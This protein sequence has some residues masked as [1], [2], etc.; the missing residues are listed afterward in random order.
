MPTTETSLQHCCS[1]FNGDIISFSPDYTQMLNRKYYGL[2][3]RRGIYFEL[4]YS[5]AIVNSTDRKKIISRG[6]YYHAIGKS[7]NVLLNSGAENS[8]ELRSPYDVANLGLIFGLSEE[9]GKSAIQTLS[10]SL[11]IKA[12][13]RR[14]GKTVMFVKQVE[15]SSDESD[16]KS[17]DSDEEMDENPTKRIKTN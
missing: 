3:I 14:H 7:K 8:F 17:S 6:H 2:A 12:E 10:R 1:T 9:Q 5:P 11:L 16:D 13:A 4:K 15:C